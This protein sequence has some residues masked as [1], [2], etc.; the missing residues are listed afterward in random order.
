MSSEQMKTRTRILMSTQ[1]LL[2]T[3]PTKGVRMSDIAKD[4]GL[5]RQ[6][7]YLHF[8]TRSELLIATTL[9]LDETLNVDQRL[10]ASRSAEKGEER[11]R[12]YVEAWGNYIP[13]IYSV[14]R[15]LMA[16]QDTDDAAKLAWEGRMHAVREGCLAVVKQLK[17]EGNLV[18]E[19]STKQ[20]TDIL[21]GLLSVRMWE[22]YI[23]NCKWSQKRY[24]EVTHQM[25]RQVLLGH[26]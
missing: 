22:H 20:A 14:G 10:T 16:V 12:L 15:A 3:H 18:P 13:E 21:W 4:A 5:S 25:A 24:I 1:K 11:L 17:D 26:S 23:Q 2:E 9:Y 7:L 6:A 19:L 8:P